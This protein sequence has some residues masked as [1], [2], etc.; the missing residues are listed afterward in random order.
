MSTP[1]ARP[2]NRQV[3]IESIVIMVFAA[4]MYGVTYTFDKVPAILAQGIQPTAYP[5]AILAIIFILAAIQAVKAMRL[6]DIEFAEL[7]PAK[8][9]PPIV[10][11]TIGL[12]IG[13]A[14]I[15]P[16]VGTFLAMAIFLPAL[17]MLWGERRWLMMA[18]SFGGFIAFAYGLFRLLM[19][20]PLP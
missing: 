20:V 2:I 7:K 13:F 18:L 15:M 4:A 10:F 6:T 17:A 3:L 14:V 8:A 12:L 16:I 5:R 11:K 1:S 9:V 19:H